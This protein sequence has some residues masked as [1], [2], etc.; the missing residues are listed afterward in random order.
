MPAPCCVARGVRAGGAAR[1]KVEN[2]EECASRSHREHARLCGHLHYVAV[3][4]GSLQ[5]EPYPIIGHQR[6][7]PRR[8][9]ARRELVKAS[10]L[11]GNRFC[12]NRFGVAFQHEALRQFRTV[13]GQPRTQI[14]NGLGAMFGQVVGQLLAL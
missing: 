13:M 5:R 11:P 3:S 6:S 7:L 10:Q 12:A 8:R 4:T 2:K 9:S 14:G 1:K